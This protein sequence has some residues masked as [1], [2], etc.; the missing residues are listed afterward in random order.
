M[1][2]AL[3]IEPGRI[4]V[5]DI[6][7]P[8]I[9]EGDLLVEVAA[10]SICGTDLRIM[11]HGHFRIPEGTRRV[12]GHELTGRIVE[13]GRAVQGFTVGDRVSVAPNVGCGTCPMCRRGL[14][15]L[16]PTYDAFGITWDGGFQEYLRIPAAAIERGNVFRVPDALSDESAALMEPM[17]C[18]LHGQRKVAVSADDSVLIIGA[19]PIGCFHTVLAKRAGARQVIVA[20]T[21]QPRLDI[22]GR[23]GADHLVNVGESDLRTE[24]ME[25]T[26]GAGADVVITCVSK[27]EVIA[28]TTD[29]AGRLGRINVFSGLGDQAR[30]QI[31]VN[32]LHY[33]EQT[34]TGTTGSS[35]RDY[36]DVI[37]IVADD[38]ID[39]SPIVSARFAL[40][41]IEAAM[42][43]SRSGAG[44][45][46]L[47]TFS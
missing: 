33:R 46:S 5:D 20:N 1:R 45:K 16:C 24:V 21:R 35:V 17:S 43:H 39:L 28:S 11:K 8:E 23:L 30:P 42:D 25:L 14:N 38:A 6:P 19:G 22:A 29:L 31:D 34:L 10:A 3:F 44:M 15:Q 9:G 7:I 27:P 41:E 40:D 26:G 13:T 18:C 2:A 47:L 37:D 32:A 12:L 36:G 4:E